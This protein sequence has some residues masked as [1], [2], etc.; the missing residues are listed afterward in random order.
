MD[1][2][3]PSLELNIQLESNPLKSRILV[4]RLAVDAPWRFIRSSTLSTCL[5]QPSLSVLK[6]TPGMVHLRLR[7]ADRPIIVRGFTVVVRTKILHV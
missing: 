2:I 4:L 6:L 5:K 1:V 7:I 3:I